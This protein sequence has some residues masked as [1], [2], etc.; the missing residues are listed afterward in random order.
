MK[1]RLKK[2]ERHELYSLFLTWYKEEITERNNWGFCKLIDEYT[3]QAYNIS[4]FPE[5]MVHKPKE[6]FYNCYGDLSSY[7]SQ[8][9]FPISDTESRIKILE[10]AIELTK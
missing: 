9:W 5:L 1:T 10:E 7:S 4:D 2:S 3:I 8:F 6:I